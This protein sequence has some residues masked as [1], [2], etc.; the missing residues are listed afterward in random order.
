MAAI[1]HYSKTDTQKQ[2]PIVSQNRGIAGSA[3][4]SIENA[5]LPALLEVWRVIEKT[6]GHRWQSTSYWRDSPS[7]RRGEALDL[8]P[9]ITPRDKLKYAAYVGSDPVL[10][11]RVPLI[12]AL[13][14]I[15]VTYRH[16]LYDIGI[17]IEP[18]HLHI[19]LMCRTGGPSTRIFK[20]KQPKAIYGD[21]LQRMQLPMIP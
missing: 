7:H 13:Q 18:D 15:A 20:W 19:Q 5:F 6:T 21:T 17:Y 12:R 14:H 9:D 3:T 11:K 2:W 16:P 4:T 1:T 10:Y 8:A